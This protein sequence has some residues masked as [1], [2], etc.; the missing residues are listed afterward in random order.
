[1]KRVIS[2]TT[3]GVHCLSWKEALGSEGEKPK[4]N[5]KVSVQQGASSKRELF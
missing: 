1:M 2:I 4:G 3:S 5:S